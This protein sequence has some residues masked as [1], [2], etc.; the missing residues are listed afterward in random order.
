MAIRL[1]KSGGLTIA[2]CAAETNGIEGDHYIDDDGHYALAAKFA[3]DKAGQPDAQYPEEWAEMEKHKLRDAKEELDKWIADMPM[4]EPTPLCLR[5]IEACA[6][7]ATSFLVGDPANGIPLRNPMA[8]E[9]ATKIRA[10]ASQPVGEG[11]RLGGMPAGTEPAAVHVLAGQFDD[12]VGDWV[13]SV[14]STPL[15]MPMTHWWPLP[16]LR[17]AL[18]QAGETT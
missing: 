7:V 13:F 6:K 12:A 4:P 9:I 1:R 17:A 16:D 18:A 11:E 10:L 14:A 15:T 5:T 3:Q 8:H 2:L